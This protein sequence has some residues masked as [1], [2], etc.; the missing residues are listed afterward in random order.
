MPEECDRMREKYQIRQIK[1][2]NTQGKAEARS[3]FY[4]SSHQ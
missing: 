4:I 1:K 3:G 2:K